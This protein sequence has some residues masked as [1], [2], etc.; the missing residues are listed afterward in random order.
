[1]TLT[2]QKREAFLD[3]IR[4]MKAKGATG[5]KI[6]L[7][8]DMGRDDDNLDCCSE[9]TCESCKGNGY[10]ISDEYQG[11]AGCLAYILAEVGITGIGNN[12]DSYGDEARI[13]NA[14]PWLRYAK[15]YNDGSVDSEMTFT[16][17]LDNEADALRILNITQAFKS[18][19]KFVGHTMNVSGAGMH[20]AVLFTEDA[21]YPSSYEGISN[22][23]TAVRNFTKSMTELLPALYFLG[24]SGKNWTRPMS[25]R[26]PRV[27]APGVGNTNSSKYSAI[28]FTGGAIEFRVFD[29]CYD[30]ILQLVDNTIVM[31]NSLRFLDRVYKPTKAQKLAAGGY[32]F[33]NDQDRTL[34]RLY[35]D[36]KLLDM[37]TLGIKDL[38]PDYYTLTEL[39]KQHGFTL[40]KTKMNNRKKQ[41][42]IDAELA[43]EEYAERY[44]AMERY[45]RLEME[46]QQIRNICNKDNSF[47]KL[48]PRTLKERVKEDVEKHVAY[49]RRSKQ[50]KSSFIER[51]IGNIPRP[52]N[53]WDV[54]EIN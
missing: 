28:H 19:E 16:I 52:S 54:Y 40:N 49:Y 42:L 13:H 14:T 9:S 43:Y 30:N 4:R 5:L 23:S 39:K 26:E 24:A 8:A 35:G 3:A 33:G 53:R 22:T 21:E 45:Y 47:A 11:A 12:I 27:S 2:P 29:T 38:K 37:M 20:M 46:A 17:K 7:E 48:A 6:E 34:D 32:R 44:D 18:I 1:M 51:F 50:A 10:R 25:Y 15:F 36:V 41:A 31:A